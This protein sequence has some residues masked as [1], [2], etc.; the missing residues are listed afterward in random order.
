M[1]ITRHIL[2]KNDN[3]KRYLRKKM[4]ITRDVLGKNDNNKKYLR[5][6]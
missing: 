3:N 4:I 1:I 6:K 2:G 5:V